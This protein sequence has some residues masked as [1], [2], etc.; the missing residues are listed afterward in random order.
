[1]TS[2]KLSRAGRGGNSV[3]EFTLVGI[4]MIF[5]L[6]SSFEMSRGMWIYH[7][8]ANSVKVGARYA[9][10]HGQLC[11]T[12]PKT[13]T[14]TAAQVAAQVQNGG[15]GLDPKQ[16]SLTF[17]TQGVAPVSC[18]LSNCLSKSSGCPDP[19]GYSIGNTFEID[20][21]YP[22]TSMISMFWPGSFSL[23]TMGTINLPAS[24]KMRI[25]F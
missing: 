2:S 24:S 1:M 21:T 11:A 10:V 18:V 23:G 13:C 9:S 5:L 20:A 25:Q 4:P 16:L 7:T 15:I 12:S 22:F 14:V 6:I 3:L 17:T 19:A 8:L